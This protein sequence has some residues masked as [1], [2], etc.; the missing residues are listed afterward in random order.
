MNRSRCTLL[1]SV[2][3][4]I[5]AHVGKAVKVV[6]LIGGIK[7]PYRVRDLAVSCSVL[8]EV[9]PAAGILPPVQFQTHAN[10]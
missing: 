1:H 9:C 2:L 10:L 3:C 8:L 4:T 6:N 5:D 7:F